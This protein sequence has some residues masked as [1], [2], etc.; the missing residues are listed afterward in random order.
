MRVGQRLG[1]VAIAE[2]LNQDL[3][4]NPPPEP[5]DPSRTRGNWCGSSIREILRNP[6]Y[7]GYMVWNRHA[8]TTGG[9]RLNPVS[10]WVWSAEPVHEAIVDPELFTAAQQIGT[11]TQRRRSKQPNSTGAAT[12]RYRSMV[13]CG[14]CGLLMYGKRRQ[15]RTYYSCHPKRHSRPTGHPAAT[16]LREELVTGALERFFRAYL[17]GAARSGN[18]E[19]LM[20]RARAE[21][22]ERHRRERDAVAAALTEVDERRSKLV[23]VLE[24]A[25]EV[26]S[27]LIA[28]VADRQR[29]LGVERRELADRLARLERDLEQVP[30]QE[31]IEAVPVVDLELGRLPDELVRRLLEAFRVELAYDP[32][33]RTLTCRA[34]VSRA[35]IPTLRGLLAEQAKRP[36]DERPTRTAGD[37]WV[38]DVGRVGLEPT[39]YGF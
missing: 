27:E 18:L 16:Y 14:Q 30:D 33:R 19:A 20:R 2:R 7:T 12:Y 10:E 5:G 35:L 21:G 37:V 3:V 11:H 34:A 15:T 22:P 1:Y 25:D 17:T 28:G 29:Q 26:D 4:V 24:I 31:V 39:L 9:N 13:R 23:R 6:K 36:E 38:C 32:A 8:T